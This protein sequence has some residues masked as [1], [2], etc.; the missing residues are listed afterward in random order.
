[1]LFRSVEANEYAVKLDLLRDASLRRRSEEA[2]VSI[3]V[4]VTDSEERALGVAS[5]AAGVVVPAL[6][7]ALPS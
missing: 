3:I 1:M 5:R 6:G 2:L 7:T 4:P